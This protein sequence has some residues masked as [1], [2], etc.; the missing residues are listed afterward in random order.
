MW[1]EDW[2]AWAVGLDVSSSG[3]GSDWLKSCYD[4]CVV[5]DPDLLWGHV[6]KML[7]ANMPEEF[8][9][10]LSNLRQTV[11]PLLERVLGLLQTLP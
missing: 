11:E 7:N 10:W 9:L 6:L 2:A 3:F 5:A 8:Y 4:V 1:F